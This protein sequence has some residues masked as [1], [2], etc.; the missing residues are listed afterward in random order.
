MTFGISADGF[1][2]AYDFGIEYATSSIGMPAKKLARE[3][4]PFTNGSYDFSKVYGELF[5]DDRTLAY[6]FELLAD[7]PEELHG[8]VAR[9]VSWLSSIHDSEIRDDQIP[10]YHFVGSCSACDVEY[11]DDLLKAVVTASFEAYPFRIAD[12]RSEA[13]LFVGDNTVRNS[14]MSARITVIPDGT[15]TIALGPL[16]QTFSG[17]TVANIY[18]AHGDNVVTVSGGSA[19]IKWQEEII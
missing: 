13:V 12:G 10:H 16:R 11:D 6:S 4:V 17:E 7:S 18:L 9:L 5:Y 3:S 2:S 1:H 14:G 15:V 8:D 19:R